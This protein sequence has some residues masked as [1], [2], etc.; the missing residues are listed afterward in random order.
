MSRKA[1]KPQ[2][3]VALSGLTQAAGSR[4]CTSGGHNVIP[5]E[6]DSLTKNQGS[7]TNGRGYNLF[8]RLNRAPFERPETLFGTTRLLDQN[9]VIMSW[10]FAAV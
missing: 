8:L 7:A 2:D 10:D 5:D 4:R 9:C 6:P 3:S 1:L